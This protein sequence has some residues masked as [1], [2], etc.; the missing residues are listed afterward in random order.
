M[1]A[2][3]YRQADGLTAAELTALLNRA[4]KTE[5]MAG[6]SVAIYNPALDPGGDGA[7]LLVEIVARA[8]N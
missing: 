3:D 1:P 4:S 7:R 2:V 5:R 6:L 8:L